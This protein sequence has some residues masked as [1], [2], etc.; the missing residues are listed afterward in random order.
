MIDIRPFGLAINLYRAKMKDRDI[1]Y[2]DMPRPDKF[3]KNL[4]W[5]DDK[6]LF[7]KM[8]ATHKLPH[9]KGDSFNSLRSAIRYFDTLEK[10]VIIKP[11]L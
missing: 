3:D 5:I 2:M 8:L 7:K 1:Y 6:Y 4:E 9:A 10:P 11:R